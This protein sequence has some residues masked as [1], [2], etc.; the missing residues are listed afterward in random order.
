M[1]YMP[2]M[3]TVHLENPVYGALW[4][5]ATETDKDENDILRRLL[6]MPAGG[7]VSLAR[8]SVSAA[9]WSADGPGF[10]DPRY[11]VFFPE[12]FSIFRTYRGKS[13]SARVFNGKWS[14]PDR[15]EEFE[16]LNSLNKAVGASTENAWYS[17]SYVDIDGK[18]KRIG[19]L[20]DPEEVKRRSKK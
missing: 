13:Y 16:S 19:E 4:S 3:K 15:T 1:P 9:S 14:M 17:W 8:G 10:R 11:N 7:G 12:G 20:R 2:S 5:F 6:R 18:R